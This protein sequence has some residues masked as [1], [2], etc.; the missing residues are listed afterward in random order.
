MGAVGSFDNF[1]VDVESFEWQEKLLSTGLDLRIVFWI[2]YR[3]PL[4]ILCNLVQ[5]FEFV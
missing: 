2:I 5:R 4:N 1:V 3:S